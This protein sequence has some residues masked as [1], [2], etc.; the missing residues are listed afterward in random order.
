MLVEMKGWMDGWME[1]RERGTSGMGL[2][3]RGS[4]WIW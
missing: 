3:E 1:A 2:M 4:G